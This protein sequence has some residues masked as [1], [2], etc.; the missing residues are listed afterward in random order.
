MTERYSS[1][2]VARRTPDET[3]AQARAVVRELIEAKQR[4]WYT[5]SRGRLARGLES[6]SDSVVNGAQ[7][8]RQYLFA[9]T[10]FASYAEASSDSER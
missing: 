5:S 6:V 1:Q 3:R 2:A 4:A 7:K 8:D 9:T 10:Y